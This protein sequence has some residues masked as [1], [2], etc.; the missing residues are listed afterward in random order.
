MNTR[1]SNYAKIIDKDSEYYKQVFEVDQINFTHKDVWL[2]GKDQDFDNEPWSFS[3]IQF[4]VTK[5]NEPV[6]IG[7]EYLCLDDEYLDGKIYNFVGYDGSVVIYYHDPYCGDNDMNVAYINKEDFT[8]LYPTNKKEFME[9][10]TCRAK[11]GSPILCKGCIHN[12]ELISKT[13]IKITAEKIEELGVEL[14]NMSEEVRE[15]I[16]ELIRAF[17]RL[18]K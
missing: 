8:S 6:K 17:N 1:Y 3:Q 14:C 4:C 5:D 10:D 2:I 18:S 16:N 15:K 9:C 12:R 11:S 13:Q 7:E